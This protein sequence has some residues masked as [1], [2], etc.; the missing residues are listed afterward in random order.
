MEVILREDVAHLGNIGEI[1]KV[2][3][4][5]A[6]NYLFPRGLAILADKRNMRELDHH[7]RVVDEKRKRVV[8]A[9]QEVAE[10]ISKVRLE[11][12]ARAGDGGKLFGSI[13]N[14]DIEKMLA[15]KGFAVERRR[16]RLEDPIKAVGE[17]VVSI[18]LGAGVPCQI[19]VTVTAQQEDPA[20]VS[21]EGGEAPP[22]A[23]STHSSQG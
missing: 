3:D 5:Y 16:I 13:T 7:R 6:R 8:S 11:F 18:A 4:G 12:S 15:D 21:S 2:K 20:P 1:V 10:R 23:G 14:M 22:A 9:A 17:H 19:K